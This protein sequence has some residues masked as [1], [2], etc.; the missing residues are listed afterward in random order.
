M[1]LSYVD[2]VNG[3]KSPFTAVLKHS[4]L[5]S[6][7]RN[8]HTFVLVHLMR[9]LAQFMMRFKKILPLVLVVLQLGTAVFADFGHTDIIFGASHSVQ[10]LLS[11]DCG[12]KERH[13]DLKDI[14]SCQACYRAANFVANF[15]TTTAVSAHRSII[16]AR[17]LAVVHA[18]VDFHS[19]SCPKR[20]PPST[21]S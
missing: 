10:S 21:I 18:S 7:E 16:L 9:I 12:A 14:H 5:Q 2:Y 13:K 15:N 20:G 1:S 17:P 19:T 11:H 8:E 6:Q 3:R 4:C